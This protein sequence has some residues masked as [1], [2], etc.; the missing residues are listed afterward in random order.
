MTVSYKAI[1][2]VVLPAVLLVASTS[3]RGQSAAE[4]FTA[5]AAVKTAG[6][7]SASAPVTIS[8]DRKMSPRE[9]EPKPT[10]VLGQ[11]ST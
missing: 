7:A 11:M 3:L 6:G 8:I 2:L 4:V 5:T 9:A 1:G 10:R